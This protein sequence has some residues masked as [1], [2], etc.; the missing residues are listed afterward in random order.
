MSTRELGCTSHK[1][2]GEVQHGCH[3][4]IKVRSGLVW[5]FSWVCGG[6][7]KS[8]TSESDCIVLLSDKEAFHEGV[9]ARVVVIG[10]GRAGSLNGAERGLLVEVR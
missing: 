9:I 4:K 7:W 5:Q 10:R 6:L 2:C 3:I 1:P 8:R